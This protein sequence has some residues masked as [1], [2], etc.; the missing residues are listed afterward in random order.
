MQYVAERND[1]GE[2]RGYVS[3]QD[4]LVREVEKMVVPS[5]HSDMIL[6]QPSKGTFDDA[7]IDYTP[8]SRWEVCS[9]HGADTHRSQSYSGGRFV[10]QYDDVQA[11][12]VTKEYPISHSQA[13][14]R[15]AMSDSLSLDGHPCVAREKP[16]LERNPVPHSMLAQ[17]EDTRSSAEA[18]C[19]VLA[20]I[21]PSS[22]VVSVY[23]WV[24]IVNTP[25][26][27]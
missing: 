4:T 11:T 9:L 24:F 17:V 19:K 16:R 26:F 10:N 14:T 2:S 1:V 23:S 20:E 6:A 25:S 21:H 12:D 13:S 15:M 5:L 8:L 18:S 3:V 27:I 7:G 22:E